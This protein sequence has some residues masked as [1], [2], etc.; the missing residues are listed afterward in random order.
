MHYD[1]TDRLNNRYIPDVSI[2]VVINMDAPPLSIELQNL[3]KAIKRY[4]SL[5][6]PEKAHNA[7]NGNARIIMF[8]ARDRDRE[9]F[10]MDIEEHFGITRSTASRVL[11]LMEKKGLMER[12][13]VPQDARLKRI[14]LTD[15]ANA[16][17]EDLR[18]NAHRMEELLLE[19]ITEGELRQTKDTIRQ[20]RANIDEALLE[21]LEDD[22]KQE[23][24][25]R[26]EQEDKEER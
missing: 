5:T 4:L 16:I 25:R 19:G 23:R 13:S 7:T 10:Q 22:T 15:D 8:L 11:S 20:M 2:E 26:S 3:V 6:M 12:I 18:G 24:E 1:E 17:V 21:V 14:V 9:I